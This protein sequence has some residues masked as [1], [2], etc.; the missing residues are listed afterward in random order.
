M[1][2]KDIRGAIGR[3]IRRIFLFKEIRIIYGLIRYGF[4]C[5][6]MRNFKSWDQESAHLGRN[7][8]KHN[9]SNVI[10]SI[11]KHERVHHIVRPLLAI[12][13]IN[14]RLPFLKVLSVGPRSEAELLLYAGYGFTWKNLRGLDLFSYSPMIDVGDMH[15]MPYEDNS[16]DV[17]F[18]GWVLSYSEDRDRA[19]K[20]MVRVLKPHGYI[21]FGNGYDSTL[22]NGVVQGNYAG[23]ST[24]PNDL[25]GF[26]APIKD[27]IDTMFFR[28]D[29]TPE[30]M[31]KGQ[32]AI[33]GVFSIKK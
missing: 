13:E 14:H 10:H 9:S 7:T 32:R 3:R 29:I 15:D 28:H 18:L 31:N 23:A 25:D 4:F 16:F 22:K 5:L 1:P 26:L 21:A 20:E 17:I 19:L 11:F 6:L 2:K 12:D 24:R 30:M 33:L 27:H 8:L